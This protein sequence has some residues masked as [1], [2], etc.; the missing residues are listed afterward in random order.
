MT[1][2]ERTK[3]LRLIIG[4]MALNCHHTVNQ[5][6]PTEINNYITDELFSHITMA[7]ALSTALQDD[8]IIEDSLRE[9]REAL[10]DPLKSIETMS[11]CILEYS[12]QLAAVGVN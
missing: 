7:V 9:C 8:G 1:R 6:N 12:K 10:P 4:K 5:L 3:R 2:E 11:N